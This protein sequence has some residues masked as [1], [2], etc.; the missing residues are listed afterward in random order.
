MPAITAEQCLR[1]TIPD[2]EL[3]EQYWNGNGH[4]SVCFKSLV[5]DGIRDTEKKEYLINNFES[6]VSL[7]EDYLSAYTVS[8]IYK[9]RVMVP[10]LRKWAKNAADYFGLEM[11]E[12]DLF[13]KYDYK[14]KTIQLLKELQVRGGK[15]KGELS[16]KLGVSEKTI[17][18]DLR[19]LSPSL[20]RS[21]TKETEDALRIGGYVVNVEIEEIRQPDNSKLY[22]T[23]NTVHPLVMLPN[24]TQV[25]VLLSSLAQKEDSDVAVSI[26]ADIWLQ[27]TDYCKGKI[28]ENF[29]PTDLALKNFI[30]RINYSLNRG[31]TTVG[32]VKERNMDVFAIPELLMLAFKAGRRC[33]IILDKD[34]E[35][36]EL[37][38]QKIE[39][40]ENHYVAVSAEGSSERVDFIEENVSFIELI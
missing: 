5:E 22:Y 26:G 30:D 16:E 39:I 20:K 33:N 29:F 13:A 25:A 3:F 36:I 19:L 8:P 11:E 2:P 32:F 21:K 10:F 27:L 35:T 15:T 28:E 31:H 17:Q 38:D 34:G 18:T 6:F 37:N 14:D 23:P 4:N 7:L 12:T 9:Q 1:A 24:V 40:L